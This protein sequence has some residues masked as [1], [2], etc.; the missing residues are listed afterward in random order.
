MTLWLDIR[1]IEYVAAIAKYNSITLAA[2]ELFITQ[3]ALSIYLS[4]LEARLGIPL[5]DRIGKKFL[6]TYAGEQLLEGGKDILRS[7]DSI[8]KQF[9]EMLHYER[10]RLR[11]GFPS[12]RGISF[13]PP[14]LRTFH[15]K[16]P[17]IEVVTQEDDAEILA[18]RVK[19]G[20]LDIAFFNR[21]S[22]DPL[23]EYHPILSDPIVLYVSEQFP[24]LGE[25]KQREG[26]PY[27]WIDL[28]L[29]E[30]ESFILN[31]PDQKTYQIT[32]QIFHDYDMQPDISVQMQNQLTSIHLAATGCGIYLA[33]EYFSRNILFSQSPRL[34]SFGENK[35]YSMEFVAAWRKGAYTPSIV[36]NFVDIARQV[37]SYS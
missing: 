36:Q 34:L 33:P 31:Y 16:Y 32:E 30:H 28:K 6:L 24:L 29:C 23:L 14:V 13:F 9:D 3:P 37:Y 12:I 8:Q 20:E 5:F 19:S 18:T 15:E 35:S 27:P 10:G 21:F 4:K 22:V 25:A 1:D 17:K 11:V 7:R 2:Q 26:F